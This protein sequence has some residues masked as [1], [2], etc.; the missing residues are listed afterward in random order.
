MNCPKCG[1]AQEQR[2]DCKKC[3][4]VFS[5]YYA[6][7]PS[8][9]PPMPNGS[10]EPIEKELLEREHGNAIADLQQEIRELNAR[11][12]EMESEKAE[13]NRLRADVE[14]LQTLLR[15]SLD[16]TSSRLDEFDKHLSNSP[17]ARLE[18]MDGDGKDGNQSS[19]PG[20]NAAGNSQLISELQNQL[21][22]LREQVREMQCLLE[23]LQQNR[24]NEEPRGMLGHDVHAIRENLDQLFTLIN[25][26]T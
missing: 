4:V 7:Y 9:R 11:F 3:G 24:I 15:E 21:V 1:F 20:E 22:E 6:L 8:K 23:Q 13:R 25:K 14:S 10:E 17:G 5:K 26:T 18:T 2:P 16:L 19:R 12:D